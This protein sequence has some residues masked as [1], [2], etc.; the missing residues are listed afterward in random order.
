MY[1]PEAFSCFFPEKSQN[2]KHTQIDPKFVVNFH[3]SSSVKIIF[4]RLILY[5]MIEF[6]GKSRF[7]NYFHT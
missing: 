1:S 7:E 6:S 3:K 2:F 5:E 4:I